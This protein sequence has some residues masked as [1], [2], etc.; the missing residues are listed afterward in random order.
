MNVVGE[1]SEAIWKLE[2]G[3][4]TIETLALPEAP[5]YGGK[6]LRGIKRSPSLGATDLIGLETGRRKFFCSAPRALL[7]RQRHRQGNYSVSG[8]GIRI[9]VDGSPRDQGLCSVSGTDH[10]N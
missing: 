9:D 7:C 3:A 5:S 2:P 1:T 6:S 10:D 8:C 4:K